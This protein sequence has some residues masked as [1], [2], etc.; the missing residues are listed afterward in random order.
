MKSLIEVVKGDISQV[1][2]S[3]IVFVEEID[4]LLELALFVENNHRLLTNHSAELLDHFLDI[5]IQLVKLNYLKSLHELL[6]LLR[7][8]FLF[9]QR[10]VLQILVFLK[11]IV[12]HKH[13][14]GTRSS[15][16]GA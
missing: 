9:L 16:S 10:F 2:F 8:F 7:G 5:V 1:L 12:C 11:A 6:L 3:G 4:E 13:L 14:S 15:G